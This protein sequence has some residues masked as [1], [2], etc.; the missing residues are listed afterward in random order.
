MG[1][2]KILAPRAN[3]P[4]PPLP[5]GG[6]RINRRRTLVCLYVCLAGRFLASSSQSEFRHVCVYGYVYVYVC[7]YTYVYIY[8]YMYWCVCRYPVYTIPPTTQHTPCHINYVP[9]F[10]LR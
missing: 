10:T 3:R 5:G 7:K 4:L 1:G 8:T 9:E 2:T 6:L